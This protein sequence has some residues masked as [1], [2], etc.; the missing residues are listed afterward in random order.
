VNEPERERERER[1]GI[2]NVSNKGYVK[3]V[4]LTLAGVQTLPTRAFIIRL[5]ALMIFFPPCFSAPSKHNQLG[6]CIE[7]FLLLSSIHSI[8]I[9]CHALQRFQLIK[10][11]KFMSSCL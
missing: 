9:L 2:S 6:F 11:L 8:R 10:Q 3:R 4:N 7:F 1:E 5:C